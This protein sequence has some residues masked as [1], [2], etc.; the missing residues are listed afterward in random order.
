MNSNNTSNYTINSCGIGSVEIIE[1]NT[2]IC[3]FSSFPWNSTIVF[4]ASNNEFYEVQIT[5]Q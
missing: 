3:K 4:A 2:F 5:I 1:D